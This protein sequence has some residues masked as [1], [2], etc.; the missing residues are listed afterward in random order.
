[1]IKS[2]TQVATHLPMINQEGNVQPGQGL[3]ALQTITYFVVAPIAI[4]AVIALLSWVASAP[5]K[6]NVDVVN[7]II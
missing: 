5:K 3:T 2:L 7:Q 1:M 4:F 6:E